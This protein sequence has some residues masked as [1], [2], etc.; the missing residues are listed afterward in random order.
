VDSASDSV[1]TAGSD[2]QTLGGGGGSTDAIKH[3]IER[4][5]R[6]V[7]ER[8]DFKRQEIANL[9]RTIDYLQAQHDADSGENVL[10]PNAR[11]R[12]NDRLRSRAH[13]LESDVRW[14]EKITL[15][16]TN[17]RNCS[18]VPVYYSKNEFKVFVVSPNMTCGALVRQVLACVTSDQSRDPRMT[19][20]LK[21]FR[22]GLDEA[23]ILEQMRQDKV[24]FC[25]DEF[26]N[27]H[28]TLVCN[29]ARK[30]GVWEPEDLMDPS[31]RNQDAIGFLT[32]L[33]IDSHRGFGMNGGKTAPLAPGAPPMLPPLYLIKRPPILASESIQSG[34]RLQ[35]SHQEEV[36]PSPQVNQFQ[37]GLTAATE[38][39]YSLPQTASMSISRSSAAGDKDPALSLGQDP[40]V[41]DNHQQIGPGDASSDMGSQPG[42]NED[43][44]SGRMKRWLSWSDRVGSKLKTYASSSHAQMAM[45][46][47]SAFEAFAALILFG[48]VEE[49]DASVLNSSDIDSITGAAQSTS[50]GL[51][52]DAARVRQRILGKAADLMDFAWLGRNNPT[53]RLYCRQLGTALQMDRPPRD[54]WAVVFKGIALGSGDRIAHSI[55]FD[56]FRSQYRALRRWE[57]P[58]GATYG[59]RIDD[60]V[61]GFK[62]DMESTYEEVVMRIPIFVWSR[63]VRAVFLLVAFVLIIL[64]A[65]ENAASFVDI[66]HAFPSPFR[67]STAFD[68]YYGWTLDLCSRMALSDIDRVFV[69]QHRAANLPAPGCSNTS[70]FSEFSPSDQQRNV[71]LIQGN[72]WAPFAESIPDATSSHGRFAD[73]PTDGFPLTPD[74]PSH[75]YGRF[76]SGLDVSSR[77]VIVDFNVKNLALGV[78]AHGEYITELDSNGAIVARLQISQKTSSVQS[79]SSSTSNGFSTFTIYAITATVLLG[80][81]VLI[82]F[83]PVLRWCRLCNRKRDQGTTAN[84]EGEDQEDNKRETTTRTTPKEFLFMGSLFAL[85]AFATTVPLIVTDYNTNLLAVSALST[86]FALSVSLYALERS[87]SR[88]LWVFDSTRLRLLSILIQYVVFVLCYSV[89]LDGWYSDRPYVSYHYGQ[90]ALAVSIL[91]IVQNYA[92]VLFPIEHRTFGDFVSILFGLVFIMIA[93]TLVYL[94][95]SVVVIGF[96]SWVHQPNWGFFTIRSRKTYRPVTDNA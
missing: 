77:A 89:A 71:S 22:K 62:H 79:S 95:F 42:G 6:T 72:E 67:P 40:A 61:K 83:F 49:N 88:V 18:H 27:K 25:I 12:L 34:E 45:T 26:E 66:T 81:T 43:K 11:A 56:E 63:R 64:A 91:G 75:A 93:M 74:V 24:R 78:E 55:S 80:V 50:S 44:G 20:Y 57:L 94:F 33:S 14:T 86:A 35:P 7:T 38:S 15:S 76:S 84:R 23:L 16:T 54:L 8:L 96:R 3:R 53:A 52:S 68:D 70:V 65:L 31:R 36:Q 87:W 17:A 19:K 32:A 48:D 2:A 21:M 58:G 39:L 59:S 29:T 13:Q 46:E 60:L 82:I 30:P 37:D 85:L 4:E 10:N 1:A 5:V 41:V 73:Y 28:F 69:R 90:T 51:T 9:K 92:Y 47:S